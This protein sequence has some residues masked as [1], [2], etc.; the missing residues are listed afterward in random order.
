MLPSSGTSQYYQLEGEEVNPV[1]PTN[2]APNLR[3][4]VFFHLFHNL[5]D[6][7]DLSDDINH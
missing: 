6:H 3:T 2:P 1:N 4:Q 7:V 5:C